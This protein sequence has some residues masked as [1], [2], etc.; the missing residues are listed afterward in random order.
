VGNFQ[1]Y[2]HRLIIAN[3]IVHGKIYTKDINLE[4]SNVKLIFGGSGTGVWATQSS[5]PKGTVGLTWQGVLVVGYDTNIQAEIDHL[6]TFGLRS[7]EAKNI[8]IY[9][10]LGSIITHVNAHHY[11]YGVKATH[12]L[13]FHDVGMATALICPAWEQAL[14]DK[15]QPCL[16]CSATTQTENP[17]Y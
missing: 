10:G 1:E 15:A 11:S 14:E 16:A 12:P 3:A 2:D 9:T 4:L 13:A 5:S 6:T 17:S 7:S 8:G